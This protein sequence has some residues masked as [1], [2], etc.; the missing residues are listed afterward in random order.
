[1]IVAENTRKSYDWAWGVF[2]NWCHARACCS[3]PTST[4][5]VVDFLSDQSH[6][7]PSTLRI[8]TAAIRA[9]HLSAE[10]PSPTETLEVRDLL[11]KL[12]KA[13][14]VQDKK[15][16]IT[17]DQIE[18]L[19]GVLRPGWPIETRDRAILLLGFATGLRRSDLISIALEDLS[20]TPG[21]M[22]VRVGEETLHVPVSSNLEICPVHAVQAWLDMLCKGLANIAPSQKVFTLTR[23]AKEAKRTEFD[24]GEPP[25]SITDIGMTSHYVATMVKARAKQAGLS[26]EI[27]KHLAG[28]SLRAGA[29]SSGPKTGISI[30]KQQLRHVQAGTVAAFKK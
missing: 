9:K 16:A 24:I 2:C 28:H 3:L 30:V 26:D 8:Y 22:I 27:V 12:S 10:L 5:T 15:V 13:S 19:C 29:G 4:V 18:I 20:F 17:Q 23:Q 14:T 6:S 11:K 21:L 25:V 1:M 7:K